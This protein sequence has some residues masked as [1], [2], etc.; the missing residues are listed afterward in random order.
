MRHQKTIRDGFTPLG[1]F[2][3]AV[4]KRPP[5]FLFPTRKIE[6]SAIFFSSDARRVGPE[7][8]GPPT[9]PAPPRMTLP[10]AGTCG[11]RLQV[12]QANTFLRVPRAQLDAAVH[13]LDHVGLSGVAKVVARQEFVRLGDAGEVPHLAKGLQPEIV[14][15]PVALYHVPAVADVYAVVHVGVGV[16]ALPLN[17]RFWQIYDQHHD[18]WKKVRF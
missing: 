8:C 18:D 13:A 3:E 17:G 5:N 15:P 10:G 4:R 14:A 16:A 7:C 2:S 6:K 11:G 1:I 9:T 12:L